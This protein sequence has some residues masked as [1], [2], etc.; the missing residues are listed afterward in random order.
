MT[1]KQTTRKTP[2]A[3]APKSKATDK[4]KGP[5]VIT[6]IIEVLSKA[7]ETKPVTKED[8]LAQLVKRFPDRTPEAM[9]RTITC[10]VPSRLLKEKGIKVQSNDDKSR[11]YWIA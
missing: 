3:A 4:L 7:T 1:A 10:Q 5:G 9:T 6:S 2:K 11:G 8:L